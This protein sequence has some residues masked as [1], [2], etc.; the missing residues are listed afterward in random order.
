MPPEEHKAYGCLFALAVESQFVELELQ[1]SGLGVELATYE[2]ELVEL[3]GGGCLTLVAPTDV[4]LPKKK[5][6]MIALPLSKLKAS[7]WVST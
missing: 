7:V 2:F 6:L 4:G 5:D 3:R 1:G